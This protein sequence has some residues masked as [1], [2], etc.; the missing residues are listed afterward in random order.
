MIWGGAVTMRHRRDAIVTFAV[1]LLIFAAV[2]DI[3]TDHSTGFPLEYSILVAGTVWL[4]FLTWRLLRER[5]HAL[6]GLSLLALAGALW[7]RSAI[8]PG[9]T[10]TSAEY[11]VTVAAYLWFWIL[12]LILSWQAWRE[13]PSGIRSAT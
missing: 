5:H 3:T 2:D 12:L 6:G 9:S 10:P 8:A 11:V 7:A 13:R 4:G 1:L